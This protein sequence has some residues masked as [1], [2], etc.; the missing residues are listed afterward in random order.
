MFPENRADDNRYGTMMWNKQVDDGYGY[1]YAATL[2]YYFSDD[3]EEKTLYYNIVPMLRM[4]EVYL[5][6]VETTSDLAEANRLYAEY[7]LQ[8]CNVG[9][10]TDAFDAT[11]DRGDMLI[12]EYRREFI[13]E[14]QLFY[15]Y[16]RNQVKDMLWCDEEMTDDDYVLWNCVN[17]EFNP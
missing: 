16:K 1:F 3:A 9:L 10:L 11:S 4:S 17:T 7:M 6:A 14:G 13:A 8:G 2:K 5:I 15:T 12:A